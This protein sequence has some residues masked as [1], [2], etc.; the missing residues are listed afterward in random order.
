MF[1]LPNDGTNGLNINVVMH[2]KESDVPWVFWKNIKQISLNV[3]QSNHKS[4]WRQK[5]TGVIFGFKITTK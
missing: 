4:F 3:S 1:S 5:L 2:N